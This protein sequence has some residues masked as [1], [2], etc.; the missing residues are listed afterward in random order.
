MT[1]GA[2]T[3]DERW[4]HMNGA[5]QLRRE[6]APCASQYEHLLTAFRRNRRNVP[7]TREGAAPIFLARCPVTCRL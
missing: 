6:V 5:A 2:F 4:S 7:H 3:V 1:D